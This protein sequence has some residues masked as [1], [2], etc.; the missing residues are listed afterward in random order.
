MPLL[1]MKG[2]DVYITNNL[3]EQQFEAGCD[4]FLYNRILPDHCI[5]K[6]HELKDKYNFK[7]IVDIDDYWI[8]EDSHPLALEYKA[9]DF[10]KKQIY[11][12]KTAEEVITTN[13]Y[14]LSEIIT[15][16]PNV[17]I[18][19]NA[20]PKAGQ[21]DIVRDGS[22]FTRLF[23]QGSLTHAEDISILAPVTNNLADISK[24][25]KM[26]MAGFNENENECHKMAMDYTAGF[27]HQ[28][29]LIE[30]KH[31]ADYYEVYK[32]AD[33]CLIPLINNRFNRCKSNLKV[34][35]AANLG[36]PVICSPVG[37]YLDMPVLYARST[38]QWIS[39]IKKLVGSKNR[40]KEVGLKLKTF[41]DKH[42]NFDTVNNKRKK[43]F[44]DACNK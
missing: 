33:I 14:L 39:N 20:I 1:L 18:V 43:I 13:N 11:A 41:C 30:P 32:D 5:D 7:I 25:I 6:L 22:K 15:Y 31:P 16:N 40:Q 24:D 17:H 34:L 10:E 44:F 36:L 9:I 29:K 27:K 38:E 19:S 21:F 42:Y 2:V 37:P 23:W 28:Y 26:V 8:L 35:E 12:L 3:L 4:I